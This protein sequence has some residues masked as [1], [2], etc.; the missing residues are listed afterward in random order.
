MDTMDRLG[1]SQGDVSDITGYSRQSINAYLS[2]RR[3][4]K[5]STMID[6]TEALGIDDF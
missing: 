6:I 2:G 5:L 4:P 3:I 1:L